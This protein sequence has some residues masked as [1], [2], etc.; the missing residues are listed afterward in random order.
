[1]LMLA[2]AFVVHNDILVGKVGYLRRAIIIFDTHPLP[3]GGNIS[4]NSAVPL[5]LPQSLAVLALLARLGNETH[6]K[7]YGI[8]TKWLVRNHS[9]LPVFKKIWRALQVSGRLNSP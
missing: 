4:D 7:E 2:V 3:S 6:L 5:E 8:G 1:M 9:Q